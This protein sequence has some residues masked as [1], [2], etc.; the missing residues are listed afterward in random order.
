MKTGAN[1]AAGLS[2]RLS[3][4]QEEVLYQSDARGVLLPV[5]GAL[6]RGHHLLAA[7]RGVRQAARIAP[8]IIWRR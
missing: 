1:E 6:L 4:P 3:P 5:A 2:R 8:T 7:A